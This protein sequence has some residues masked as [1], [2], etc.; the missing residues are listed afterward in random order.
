MAQGTEKFDIDKAYKAMVKS[1]TTPG[2]SNAM[3]PDIDP[4]AARGYIPVGHYAGDLSGDNSVSHALEYCVADAA[5]AW[6]AWPANRNDIE[7][8]DSLSRRSL[9]YRHYYSPEYG[10][11]RPISADGTFVSPFNPRG[12]G[13]F[14]NAVGFHEGS[15]WNY[16][17]AVPH[18]VGRPDS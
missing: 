7:L 17:F 16:S 10:T 15:A 14:S 13:N 11:L 12:G 8:A 3:R 9:G 5:L 1:A 6:L 4:Y 2:E 18:D